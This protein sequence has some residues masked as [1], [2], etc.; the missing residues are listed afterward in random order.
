MN[1]VQRDGRGHGLVV[2]FRDGV[3]VAGGR[4][5]PMFRALSSNTSTRSPSGERMDATLATADERS[6]AKP[7]ASSGANEGR[8]NATWFS[9]APSLSPEG[10]PRDSSTSTPGN[11]TAGVPSTVRRVP[12]SRTQN[13]ALASMSGTCR[14]RCPMATPVALGGAICPWAAVATSSVASTMPAT[15][16]PR[17]CAGTR[18]IAGPASTAPPRARPAC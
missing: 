10:V 3:I 6:S 4:V 11:F 2:P 1:V 13:A 17:R 14:R 5:K 7:A 18:L 9:T 12:P 15:A 16:P 8:R